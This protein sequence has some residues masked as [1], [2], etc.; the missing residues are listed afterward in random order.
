M[1]LIWIFVFD[2]ST[3][4]PTGRNTNLPSQQ[5]E[6]ITSGKDISKTADAQNIPF[7]DG[8]ISPKSKVFE[9]FNIHRTPRSVTSMD[10]MVN[11]R[12]HFLLYNGVVLPL[13]PIPNQSPVDLASYWPNSEAKVPSTTNSGTIEDQIALT[14][15]KNKK[16]VLNK[17]QVILNKVRQLRKIVDNVE[18]QLDIMTS[19]N[20]KR[21]KPFQKMNSKVK[22]GTDSSDTSYKIILSDGHNFLNNNKEIGD[23]NEESLKVADFKLK[24]TT[25]GD[26]SNSS[27]L[28]LPYSDSP[29]ESQELLPVTTTAEDTN[30]I[31]SELN[32]STNQ[33]EL[34][35]LLLDQLKGSKYY[36][37]SVSDSI[38]SDIQGLSALVA[39][40]QLNSDAQNQNYH[41]VLPKSGKS[42]PELTDLETPQVNLNK[43]SLPSRSKRSLI[44]QNPVF[45]NVFSHSDLSTQFADRFFGAPKP[46]FPK[47]CIKVY[48]NQ[49]G[50]IHDQY[51]FKT[52]F[53]LPKLETT[54]KLIQ[55]NDLLLPNLKTLPLQFNDENKLIIPKLPNLT[56]KYNFTLTPSLNRTLNS[57]WS[58]PSKKNPVIFNKHAVLDQ[59][60]IKNNITK[61]EHYVNQNKTKPD[62][63]SY[64]PKV[65]QEEI[66][67]TAQFAHND[68]RLTDEGVK[69]LEVTTPKSVMVDTIQAPS[70]QVSQFFYKSVKPSNVAYSKLPL[71]KNINYTTQFI[72]GE[73]LLP[74]SSVSQN[75]DLGKS[76]TSTT[77]PNSLPGIQHIAQFDL[78]VSKSINQI[79]DNGGYVKNNK[80]Y[81]KILK[82][83]TLAVNT[84]TNLYEQLPKPL[85]DNI[86]YTAQFFNVDQFNKST[87]APAASNFEVPSYSKPN[88]SL[89]TSFNH[90]GGAL[91]VRLP[92]HKAK[93]STFNS[94]NFTKNSG[95]KQ[96]KHHN[97]VVYHLKNPKSTNTTFVNRTVNNTSTN[98]N[99]S[100]FVINHPNV[101]R[102]DI[103]VENSDENLLVDLVN[104][105]S[106]KL[107]K[108]EET[109]KEDRRRKVL[110]KVIKRPTSKTNTK[111]LVVSLLKSERLSSVLI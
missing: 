80:E 4:L 44:H 79:H 93:N 21:K 29:S 37:M 104:T 9:F 38:Y 60:A 74:S 7:S 24:I 85:Q 98:I 16:K 48:H 101:N 43:R 2:L 31:D 58:L 30:D 34:P 92:P 8:Q 109:T 23:K 110:A 18:L 67:Y 68:L 19:S 81:P 32:L 10:D 39:S 89:P 77:T 5:T 100:R 57:F 64:L 15:L 105:E 53:N 33:K 69:L 94:L 73:K 62:L 84:T 76:Q 22:L 91:F 20:L 14:G 12:R 107:K 65:L 42:E 96:T 102:S 6:I 26:N 106:T 103:P 72:N 3:P 111:N 25:T 1:G 97:L 75:Q 108:E 50:H 47:K 86:D 45:R 52:N 78:G 40:A 27:D 17:L 59:I 54:T 95:S 35:E 49:K 82:Y 83:N 66:K 36:D 90:D 70:W 46:V 88:D 99:G 56:K 61:S 13:K 28:N 11:S 51:L 87:P 41:V 55:P 63:K 71:Q